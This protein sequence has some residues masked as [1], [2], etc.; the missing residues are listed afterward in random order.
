METGN[1]N[2]PRNSVYE[3]SGVRE[4]N[5]SSITLTRKEF[6][7]GLGKWSKAVVAVVFLG[8]TPGLLPSQGWDNFQ[9]RIVE[10]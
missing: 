6:F 4:E 2:D 1:K 5:P 10:P 9:S 8:G 3:S 7:T